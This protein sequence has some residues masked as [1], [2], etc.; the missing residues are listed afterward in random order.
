MSRIAVADTTRDLLLLKN[1][2]QISMLHKLGNQ[3][4]SEIT[5][6]GSWIDYEVR[7]VFI[8]S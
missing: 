4:S 7:F 3:A 6:D 5:A 8:L 1:L 2:G